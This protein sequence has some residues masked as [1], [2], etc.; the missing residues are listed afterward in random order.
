MK[1]YHRYA[2]LEGVAATENK[3]HS[4]EYR[5]QIPSELLLSILA[6]K[7]CMNIIRSTIHSPKSAVELANSHLMPTNS[8]YRKLKFLVKNRILRVSTVFSEDGRKIFYYQS[9][10]SEITLQHIFSSLE[11]EIIP[12]TASDNVNSG[13]NNQCPICKILFENDQNF[14]STHN[15]E[16]THINNLQD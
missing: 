1:Y 16:S 14:L 6:D 3:A 8:V 12:N 7:Q 2:E 15:L 13:S 10:I 9:R 5:N 11:I 4:E